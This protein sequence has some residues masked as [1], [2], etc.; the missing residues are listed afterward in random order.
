[1]AIV[2]TEKD[3][4]KEQTHYSVSVSAKNGVLDIFSFMTPWD[5]TVTASDNGVESA[6]IIGRF[7]GLDSRNDE[8]WVGSESEMIIITDGGKIELIGKRT[9]V[10]ADTNT[11]KTVTGDYKTTTRGDEKV[12]F[13]ME[14]NDFRKICT[15]SDLD[16][17]VYGDK[18]NKEFSLNNRDMK[19]LKVLYNEAIDPN[20]F[21]DVK[22]NIDSDW[23]RALKIIGGVI[24]AIIFLSIIF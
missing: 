8:F 24:I 17:K 9:K 3:K 23:W 20:K 13:P 14:K 21:I 16:I 11:R 19:K 2:N 1:M 7:S 12:T 10:D 4:F 15:S 5:F 6:G 22:E 18:D